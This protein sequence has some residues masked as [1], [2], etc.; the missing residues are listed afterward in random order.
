MTINYDNN[1]TND[2]ILHNLREEN[3][4]YLNKE[5]IENG[6]AISKHDEKIKNLDENICKSN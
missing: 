1:K 5:K 6:L 4:Y 3:L 2:E